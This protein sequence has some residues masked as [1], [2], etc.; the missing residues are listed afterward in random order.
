MLK[1]A[2]HP[3]RR[4]VLRALALAP[5]AL[6]S[7]GSR[8]PAAQGLHSAPACEPAPRQ[9]EGPFFKPRSPQRASLLEPGLQGTRLVLTG[10]V[11]ST[12][13]RPAAGA[14]L[15]FW[16]ADAGGHYDNAGFRL[17]GHQYTDNA[18]RYR[19][20]TI[21][22]GLYPGRT[23]HIHVKVQAPGQPVFTTQLYFPHEAHNAADPLFDQALL[24]RQREEPWGRMGMFDFVFS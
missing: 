15:D 11:M 24:I 16:Q 20:E 12:A 13:C 14:L 10:I 22:P 1:S 2:T 6:A 4:R 7:A 23:R 8:R 18:G 9:T 21:V 19:L 5:L 17:R 3:P